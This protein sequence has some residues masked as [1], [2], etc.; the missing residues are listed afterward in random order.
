MA[1]IMDIPNEKDYQKMIKIAD[2]VGVKYSLPKLENKVANKSDFIYVP[3]INLYVAR[4]KTLLGENWFDTQKSLH[5]N[6]QKM[7]TIPEFKEFLKYAKEN[8]K[9]IYNEITEV[10]NPW[11]AEWLDADF[12][13]Q[14]KE[15]IVNYHVFDE[16]GKIVK[17]SEVLDKN[18]FMKNKT[19]GISLENWLEDST[20]SGL[21]KNLV[22]SG[23]LYYWYPRSDNNS[24][25]RFGANSG[26][27]DLNCCRIPSGGGSDLGV[28]AAKLRE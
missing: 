7:L 25:A 13:T 6:E 4:E 8:H 14:G 24:V 22:K 20:K 21:P 18:T 1:P 28:R 17:K 15:L 5:S 16:N 26:G 23:D 27:A 19:P 11:R 3:S 9:D 10:R 12:K 2:A